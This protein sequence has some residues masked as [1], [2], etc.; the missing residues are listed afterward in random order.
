MY[1]KRV[2]Q[3][4]LKRISTTIITRSGKTYLLI[5]LSVKDILE[6]IINAISKK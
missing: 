4:N 2:I 3:Y 6:L 5:Y 1:I